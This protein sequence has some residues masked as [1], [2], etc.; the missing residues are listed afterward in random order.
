MIKTKHPNAKASSHD[1]KWRTSARNGG[2]LCCDRISRAPDRCLASPRPIW[3][4]SASPC[5]R[6]CL[7]LCRGPSP[8]RAPGPSPGPCRGPGPGP[9]QSPVHCSATRHSVQ[10]EQA[11]EAEAERAWT[12]GESAA[13]PCWAAA[14]SAARSAPDHCACW[15]WRR[16][17]SGPRRHQRSGNSAGSVAAINASLVNV[18]NYVLYSVCSGF[19]RGIIKHKEIPKGQ[20]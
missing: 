17:A 20:L 8:V 3:G 6:G 15:R 18:S 12:A 14:G 9:D 10:E 19:K 1:Q 7:A 13:A 11:A 2:H 5:R 4:P 16:T